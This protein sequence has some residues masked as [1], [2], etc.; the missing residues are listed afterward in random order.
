MNGRTWLLQVSGASYRSAALAQLHT[1]TFNASKSLRTG[2]RKM[3]ARSSC[4]F[5]LWGS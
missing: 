5:G 4:R 2:S 1:H 3:G